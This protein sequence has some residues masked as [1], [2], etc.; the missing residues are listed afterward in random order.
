MALVE[1]GRGG[2]WEE[3]GGEAGEEG[4]EGGGR[5]E[6]QERGREEGERGGRGG[7][8]REGGGWRGGGV[9]QG[10]SW[11]N[12][13]A[14]GWVDVGLGMTSEREEAREMK[15]GRA[16]E[17][18]RGRLIGGHQA[19]AARVET[20]E[21]MPRGSWWLSERFERVERV[22]ECMA[23]IAWAVRPLRPLTNLLCAHAARGGWDRCRSFRFGFRW[24]NPLPHLA[25]CTYGS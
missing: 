1:G 17:G 22:C 25:I 15:R 24:L 20:R 4:E 3:E 10:V 11:K 2:G 21:K 6:R 8:E 18:E 9:G 5:G 19:G 7:R 23:C 16:S 13:Q 14:E 12:V